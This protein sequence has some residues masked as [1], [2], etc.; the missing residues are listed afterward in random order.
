[1]VVLDEA[2]MRPYK[3]WVREHTWESEALGLEYWLHY[4]G[5]IVTPIV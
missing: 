1:M 3:G 5:L 4:M 2:P